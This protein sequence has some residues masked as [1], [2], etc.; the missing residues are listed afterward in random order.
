MAFP[1]KEEILQVGC[2]ETAHY[3]YAGEPNC[4]GLFFLKDCQ[5]EKT[6]VHSRSAQE[7]LA[8]CLRKSEF[9]QAAYQGDAY[10]QYQLGVML[11]GEGQYAEC[12]DLFS[13]SASQGDSEAQVAL[14][15]CFE[16][17]KGVEKDLTSAQ[18]CYLL[19]VHQGNEDAFKF[20]SRVH[21]KL[22]KEGVDSA[23]NCLS[24]WQEDI[25]NANED[26]HLGK[27]TA[28]LAEPVRFYVEI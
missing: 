17:G 12:A 27:S 5:E 28:K 14:G 23:F 9:R 10:A 16:F 21:E 18:W 20:L 6:V 3:R 25:E 22:A 26:K 2:E 1:A 24:Q 4:L 7:T 8:I 13:L 15:V 11:L 19:A